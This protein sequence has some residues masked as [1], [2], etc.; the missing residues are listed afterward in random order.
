MKLHDYQLK[1]LGELEKSYDVIKNSGQGAG[2]NIYL[3]AP[4]GS[5]KTV[6]MGRI[7]RQN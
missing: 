1:A 4:T 3:D 6:I 2:V 5:G 7:S